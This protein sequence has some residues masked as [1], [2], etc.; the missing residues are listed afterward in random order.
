MELYLP[1]INKVYSD[2]RNNK[3]H[4]F[5]GCFYCIEY[6][7]W[8]RDS[9]VGIV[10]GNKLDRQDSIPGKEKRFFSS[11]QYMYSVAQPMSYKTGT[12]G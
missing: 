10:T 7:I 1:I 5:S 2:I 12:E 9:S 11:P 8:S 3:I 6:H 4:E